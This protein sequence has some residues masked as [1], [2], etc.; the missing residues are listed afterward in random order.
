L[1]FL[2]LGCGVREE[3]RRIV[4]VMKEGKFLVDEVVPKV[5]G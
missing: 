4:A 3:V 1:G 5:E 2:A